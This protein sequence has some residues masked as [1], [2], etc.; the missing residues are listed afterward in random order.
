MFKQT[1]P[2]LIKMGFHRGQVK[3]GLRVALVCVCESSLCG[4]GGKSSPEVTKG[5]GEGI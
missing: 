4:L 5:G 2:S 1:V 3:R